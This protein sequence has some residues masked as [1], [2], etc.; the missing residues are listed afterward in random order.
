MPAEPLRRRWVPGRPTDL[1]LT[2]GILRRGAGDPAMRI[3]GGAVWWTTRTREG[4]ATLHLRRDGDAVEAEAWGPGAGAVLDRLPTLLGDADDDSGFAPR[5]PLVAELHRRLAGL[6]ICR[7]EAVVDALVAAILGQKVTSLESRRGWARLVRGLG[8][9]APGPPGL[10]LPAEPR[11]LATAPYWVYHRFGV[12]RRRAE[13]L[14]RVGMLAA[15][16][17]EI[18]AM[19]PEGARER[20]LA[21]P[22]IG[23]WTAAEVAMVALGDADAVSVGDYNLPHMVSWALA[24]EPRGSDERML[25]LLAPYRGHRGRVLRLLEAGGMRAPRHGPRLPDR[26]LARM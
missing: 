15:R 20:L 18:V 11:R 8:E 16:L 12:E 10:L 21:L 6:R 7:T 17:E 25:E 9:P 3:G 22:G 26:D 23:P 4:P 19:T 24:G 5:H 2:L 13:T 1:G 14:Q